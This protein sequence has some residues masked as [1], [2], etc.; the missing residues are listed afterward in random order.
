MKNFST[1]LKSFRQE[2]A[3]TQS[4][5]VELLQ[6]SCES[7]V[8]LDMVTLSRW[9]RGVT[10]PSRKRQNDVLQVLGYSLS[11]ILQFE[12][13]S[14]LSDMQVENFTAKGAI[15]TDVSYLSRRKSL[16]IDKSNSISSVINNDPCYRPVLNKVFNTSFMLNELSQDLN[17]SPEILVT[18]AINHLNARL[19]IV[20][21][22]LQIIGHIF[23]FLGNKSD[24]SKIISGDEK[25]EFNKNE[26]TVMSFFS[27]DGEGLF[28]V[29]GDFVYEFIALP[30]VD[31]RATV[32][33]EYYDT[34]RYMEK[35]GFE[36]E[37]VYVIGAERVRAYQITKTDIVSSP[38]SSLETTRY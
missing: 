22:D 8:K 35:L 37:K 13:R 10:L 5:M 7:L 26:M 20:V 12:R 23:Y 17:V 24:L 21:D 34:H 6:N 2:N 33:S 1:V 30:F 16:L 28:S 3:I 38:L 27:V 19:K 9:E 11:E 18:T 14:C 31:C 29:L 4:K 32:M 36:Y 15:Y 25:V